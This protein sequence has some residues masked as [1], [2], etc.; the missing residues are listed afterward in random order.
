MPPKCCGVN[1]KENWNAYPVIMLANTRLSI[2]NLVTLG[3]WLLHILTILLIFCCYVSDNHDN[4][5]YSIRK[6]DT[7]VEDLSFWSNQSVHHELF[8]PGV[9]SLLITLHFSFWNKVAATIFFHLLIIPFNSIHTSF[10]H[11]WLV[12]K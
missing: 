5:S 12:Y 1:V 8:F 9:P 3:N 11:Y 6:K 7:L 10:M 4:F 2:L